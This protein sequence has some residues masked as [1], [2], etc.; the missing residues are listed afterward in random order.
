MPAFTVARMIVI[1]ELLARDRA[2][3][4]GVVLL[5]AGNGDVAGAAHECCREDFVGRYILE[6]YNFSG[7]R[8][9]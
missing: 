9:L 3:A 5:F 7:G 1:I 2:V 6:S 4:L 8:Q